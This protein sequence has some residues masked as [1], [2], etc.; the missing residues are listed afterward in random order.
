M[1]NG[2]LS[3]QRKRDSAAGPI[4]ASDNE[5]QKSI[6]S[7]PQRQ[8]H[9]TFAGAIRNTHGAL[10]STI[11]PSGWGAMQWNIM[12]HRHDVLMLQLFDEARAGGQALKQH[13]V[14]VGIVA[15][16]RWNTRPP[17]HALVLQWSKRLVIGLPGVQ[18][19]GEDGIGLFQL[20]P[21]KSSNQFAGQK[22]RAHIYPG[23]LIDLTA[24]Q[25]GT[26]GS[27]LPEDFGAGQETW[28][29]DEQS[30]ALP[31]NDILGFME[32]DSGKMAQ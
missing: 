27:L 32:T 1:T 30:T 9:E 31:G 5:W 7:Q 12:K 8:P 16:V 6:D 17:E 21:Q 10:C 26:V 14:Q 28:I 13:I 15:A 29:V 23:V 19:L 18:P 24:Q 11:A 25:R 2:L 4:H 22:R 3:G 20:C